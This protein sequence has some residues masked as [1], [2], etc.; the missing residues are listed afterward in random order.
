VAAPNVELVVTTGKLAA[1]PDSEA[2][3]ETLLQRGATFLR[4]HMIAPAEPNAERGG[5]DPGHSVVEGALAVQKPLASL[6][7]SLGQF[8][9]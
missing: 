9:Q 6:A 3:G 1:L 4:R 7:W 8:P 5:P 2:R